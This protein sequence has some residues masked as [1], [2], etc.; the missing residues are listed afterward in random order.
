[1][2]FSV[3]FD[4]SLIIIIDN[5]LGIQSFFSIL[6]FHINDIDHDF[7]AFSFDASHDDHNILNFCIYCHFN[8]VLIKFTDIM[9]ICPDLFL[10]S[11]PKYTKIINCITNETHKNT[12]STTN[13]HDN[14]QLNKNVS[15]A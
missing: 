12:Q 14:F 4:S 9:S 7:N 15:Y 2:M 13:N 5:V 6:P 8:C 11:Y 3:V 1:M 10:C